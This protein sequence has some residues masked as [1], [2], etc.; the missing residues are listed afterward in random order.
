MDL[1]FQ[2]APPALKVTEIKGMFSLFSWAAASASLQPARLT[3]P[4][5]NTQPGQKD[6]G[7]YLVSI[8]NKILDFRRIYPLILQFQSSCQ[9]CP[10]QTELAAFTVPGQTVTVT[11][12]AA[13]TGDK[14]EVWN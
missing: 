12:S 14:A 3:L 13:F 1:H 6:W 5:S 11:L 8:V 7:F 10:E 4:S 2:E 9:T